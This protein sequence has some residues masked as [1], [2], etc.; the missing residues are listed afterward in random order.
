MN[1][2]VVVS[3]IIDSVVSSPA[4]DWEDSADSDN[5]DDCC[6][7]LVLIVDVVGCLV[8]VIAV[9]TLQMELWE[10]VNFH[11]AFT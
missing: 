1:I 3:S 9:V 4:E 11:I 5:D 8:D 7:W 10:V 6:I 2:I